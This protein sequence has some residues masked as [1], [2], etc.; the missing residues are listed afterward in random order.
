MTRFDSFIIPWSPYALSLLRIVAAFLF[1]FHGS[2]K[3]FAY[4]S[5]PPGGRPALAS[6]YGVAGILEFLG[7]LLLLLGLFTRPVAFFLSGLMAVAY[8]TT[9]APKGFWPNLNGGESAVLF[10]F[11]FFFIMFAGPGPWSLDAL[12]RF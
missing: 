2:Q 5:A 7:G 12:L 10:C 1:T 8:F 3:L 9:H 4:P 6:L 11:I